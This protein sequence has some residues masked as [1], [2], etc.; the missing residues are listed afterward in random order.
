MEFSLIMRTPSRVFAYY[1]NSQVRTPSRF[2]SCKNPLS[3]DRKRLGQALQFDML[4]ECQIEAYPPPAIQWYSHRVTI[5][6][7]DMDLVE[8]H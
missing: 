6:F 8:F 5:I 2:F 1:L 4:L 7:S 3:V